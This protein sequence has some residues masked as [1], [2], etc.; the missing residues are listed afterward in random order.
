MLE[1][2]HL[3]EGMTSFYLLDDTLPISQGQTGIGFSSSG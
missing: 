3:G 2:S 1:E